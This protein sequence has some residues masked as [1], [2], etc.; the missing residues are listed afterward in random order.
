MNARHLVRGVL[1]LTLG[2]ASGSA[3]AQSMDWPLHDLNLSK[4]RYAPLD[5]INSSNVDKL[6]LA[7]SFDAA[8]YGETIARPTPLVVDGVMY[9]NAKTKLFA[10]NATTGNVIWNVPIFPAS[11]SS[12]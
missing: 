7:W 3:W 5:E 2:L 8:K 6:A 10:L 9:V 11:E 4:N 1:A 12:S